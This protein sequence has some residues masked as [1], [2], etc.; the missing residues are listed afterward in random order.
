ME[1]DAAYFR[2][3]AQEEIDASMAADSS[4]ARRAHLE[5]AERYRRQAHDLETNEAE[6][7]LSSAGTVSID[8]FR[9][10]LDQSPEV[11]R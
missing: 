9:D 11:T 5:L 4:S 10:P 7:T 1:Q 6:E 3:R 8:E 2:G